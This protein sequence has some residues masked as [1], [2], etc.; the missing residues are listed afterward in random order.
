MG[1][2][3]SDTDSDTFFDAIGARWLYAFSILGYAI[4]FLSMWLTQPSPLT[5]SH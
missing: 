2:H 4:G 3:L 5:R 1:I